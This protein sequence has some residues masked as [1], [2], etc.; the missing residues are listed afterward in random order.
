MKL[1][2]RRI[3]QIL[4]HCLSEDRVCLTRENYKDEIVARLNNIKDLEFNFECSSGVTKIVLR[5]TDK[6]N[7]FVI[8]IPFSGKIKMQRGSKG[9]L[10]ETYVPFEWS[11]SGITWYPGNYCDIEAERCKHIIREGWGDL[12]AKTS[13]IG[14][15]GDLYVY[16]Q[17]L[18]D[19]IA[20][21]KY[22]EQDDDFEDRL[23]SAKD[24]S[25]PYGDEI[26]EYWVME[27]ID[28]MGEE[29]T[30]DFLEFLAEWGYSN[31]LHG[32]NVGFKNG[33]PVIFDYSDY[34]D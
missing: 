6:E 19:T 3:L 28:Y 17:E 32:A 21:D 7:K 18:V 30:K 25:T 27:L 14:I 29:K 8:K 13:L 31:D 33:V 23:S 11:D 20:E 2:N 1:T 34:E 5:P 22:Y 12:I 24:L 9:I 4:S 10:E 15:V 16:K 26:D